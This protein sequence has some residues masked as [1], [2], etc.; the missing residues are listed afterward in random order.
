MNGNN[1]ALFV[2]APGVQSKIAAHQA[3]PSPEYNFSLGSLRAFITCLVV[4]HHAVLAYHPFAPP[5][6]DSLDAQPRFWQAFPV[7]DAHRS[8]VFAWF[9]GFNDNFFMSLMF[10]LSGL[11]VWKSLQRK[12][13]GLFVRDRLIRLGLP[14]LIAT[15]VLSPLAYFPTYL[16]S[17]GSPSLAG[18]WQEWRILGQWPTGPAW[19]L[20]MLLAFDCLA[21]AL[22]ALGPTWAEALSGWLTGM[23]RRPLL[24]FCALTGLSAM[25]YV[26]MVLKFTPLYWTSVGPFT[27]QTCRIFHYAIY[28]LAGI[29]LGAQGLEQSL[30][31]TDGA[32]ARRWP[33]WV[34]AA[35]G[36]FAMGAVVL[37]LAISNPGT[38]QTW[39]LLGGFAFALSCAASSFAF[40]SL[41]T[42]FARTRNTIWDS[43]SQNAYGIYLLHY[44]FV[45]WTQYALLRLMLPAMTKGSFV[46]L[47]SLL[48][49]WASIMILRRCRAVAKFI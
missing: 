10:F 13:S 4:A 27:F 47:C 48:L 42:R 20:W 28:F 23:F 37:I 2:P 1:P 43:L 38:H 15:A 31:A 5:I 12:G 34:A 29:I 6:P 45:T 21:A 24:V 32:L 46:F 40:L 25:V 17:T 22:F 16:Q 39:D 35:L 14:F 8:T 19:F 7:V 41:F 44:V 36:A 30:L 9:V 18:F 33:V 49:S 26:P 11:F 3:T